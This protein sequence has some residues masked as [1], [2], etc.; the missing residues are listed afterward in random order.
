MKKYI[1]ILV[2]FFIPQIYSLC[3][4]GQIDI[5]SATLE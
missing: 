1:L 5:N 4:E 2:I 3:N